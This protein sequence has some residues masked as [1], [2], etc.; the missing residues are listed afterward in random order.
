M[1]DLCAIMD[2]MSK[3]DGVDSSTKSN[4]AQVGYLSEPFCRNTIVSRKGFLQ[5]RN[6][7]KKTCNKIL[8]Q[9]RG[10]VSVRLYARNL[11]FR[12]LYK[13]RRAAE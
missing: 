11:K 9:Y 7:M 5:V 12:F 6:D 4:L 8:L 1:D 10:N 2:E 3:S 13:D